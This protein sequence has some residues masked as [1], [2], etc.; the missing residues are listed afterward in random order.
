MNKI[1]D[2]SVIKYFQK[3]D[4]ASKKIH[5]DMVVSLMDKAPAL[6]TVKKWALE[7]KRARKSF[8]NDPRSERSSTAT[9]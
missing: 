3:K 2:S 8:E 4:L 7:F 5:A 6:S 9:T 1:W